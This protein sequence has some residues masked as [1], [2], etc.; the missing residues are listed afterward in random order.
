M[1]RPVLPNAQLRQETRSCTDS[2]LK[3]RRELSGI[4]PTIVSLRLLP[5]SS[6]ELTVGIVS[7][8]CDGLRG[9]MVVYDPNDPHLSL[10]A[11]TDLVYCL[12]SDSLYIIQL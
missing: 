10:Y 3:T 12:V 4:T 7:Q 11:F 6:S 1:V 2:N 9:A 5:S 8:Y